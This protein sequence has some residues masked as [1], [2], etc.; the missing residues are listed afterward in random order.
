ML[1]NL[2]SFGGSFYIDDSY[3]K[4]RVYSDITEESNNLIL[5]I[6]KKLMSIND[7]DLLKLMNEYGDYFTD[8]STNTLN[9]EKLNKLK[10]LKKFFNLIESKNFDLYNFKIIKSK[11]YKK[12]DKPFNSNNFE[13]I[14]TLFKKKLK[15][16]KTSEKINNMYISNLSNLI[17]KIMSYDTNLISNENFVEFGQII[18]YI[19]MKIN[20]SEIKNIDIIKSILELSD[21][22]KLLL[23]KQQLDQQ[24]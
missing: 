2:R 5:E 18:Y 23:Q 20:N 6:S 13:G 10:K 19:I 22:Y 14:L 16:L 21:I 1:R 12:I 7:N 3:R 15:T 11:N 9:S 8:Y 24:Q 4:Y 17:T